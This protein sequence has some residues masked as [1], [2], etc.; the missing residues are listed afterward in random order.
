MAEIH[1]VVA[2]SLSYYCMVAKAAATST[3]QFGAR[4]DV[5]FA[6]AV[7]F[8]GAAYEAYR[9]IH[10]RKYRPVQLVK[11][12]LLSALAGIAATVGLLI[13]YFVARVIYLPVQQ[14]HQ[15]AQLVPTNQTCQSDLT[16]AHWQIGDQ[17]THIQ[18][19]TTQVDTL[20][21]QVDKLMKGAQDKQ[22]RINKTVDEIVNLL[23][24]DMLKSPELLNFEKTCETSKQQAAQAI[25]SIQSELDKMQKEPIPENERLARFQRRDEGRLRDRLASIKKEQTNGGSACDIDL[26]L[27]PW[28]SG[29]PRTSQ[30]LDKLKSLRQP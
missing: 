6:M 16:Q 21:R 17:K 11:D 3:G 27:R 23:P 19:L 28:P 2:A 9:R 4:H 18:T 30:L 20:Q 5:W 15:L 1:R 22:T 29:P 7:T 13:L 10:R 24:P 12:L 8:L 26:Q 14:A 25:S